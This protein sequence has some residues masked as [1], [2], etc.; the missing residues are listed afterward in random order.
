MWKESEDKVSYPCNEIGDI[1]SLE[2]AGA[3]A[4]DLKL[5]Y[6]LKYLSYLHSYVY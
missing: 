2:L 3:F 5:L 1:L 4:G 6:I